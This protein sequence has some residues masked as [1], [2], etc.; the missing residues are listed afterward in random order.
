MPSRR[1]FLRQTGIAAGSMLI[2]PSLVRA[3]ALN[4]SGKAS[5]KIGL[6]LYTVRDHMAKDPR[7]TLAR[8]AEIGYQEMEGAT[9]TGT[10]KFYG[11]D[12]PTFAGVLK[13]NGL[14]MPS[15]HYALGSP[16]TRGTI[17]SD[18][19][20]AVEDAAQLG[21]K[22]MVCAWLPEEVR[23]TLDDY[24]KVADQLNK[25]GET[26]KKHGIQLCYHN[27][28]FE[29][30]KIDGQVPY[31]VLLKRA[32]KD[33]V[34]MEMDIYWITRAGYDPIAMFKEHPGRFVL[35]HVKDMDDTSRQFFTEVGNG[36]IDWNRIF[37]H[38]AESGMQ[39]FFVEQDACPGDPFVSI[40][41]SCAYLKKN[42]VS[43]YKPV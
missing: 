31:E 1:I 35:W 20:R 33:L 2:A 25:A 21:L 30:P 6:Q 41:K 40:V 43:Q 42:I 13:Q 15:S 38:A 39:H 17:L 24:R 16:D 23:K 12:V 11:M 3:A 9:Y 22:Y 29:F 19:D 26:C 34:K 32:D 4:H 7:A 8:V 5:Y 18:W 14:T 27:H 36:V 10:E 28:N 37:A